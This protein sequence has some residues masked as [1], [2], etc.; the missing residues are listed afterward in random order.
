MFPRLI[1]NGLIHEYNIAFRVLCVCCKHNDAKLFFVQ[2]I[3]TEV[4]YSIFELRKISEDKKGENKD[5]ES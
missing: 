2:N 5:A 1:S 3:K 4:K